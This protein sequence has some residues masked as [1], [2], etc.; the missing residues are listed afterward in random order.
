METAK[1]E[2]GH[3]IT[4]GESTDAYVFNVVSE[5]ELEVGYLQNKVKAIKEPVVLEND[6]WKFKYSGPCGSYLRGNEEAIVKRGK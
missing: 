4:V 5:T 3:W 2:V 6:K 1:I